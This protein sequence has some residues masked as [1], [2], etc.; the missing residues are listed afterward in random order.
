MKTTLT[1]MGLE[2]MNAMT[3]SCFNDQGDDFRTHG[4][5][6]FSVTDELVGTG[7]TKEVYMTVQQAKGVLS[8]LVKKNYV[9]ICDAEGWGRAPDMSVCMTKNGIRVWEKMLRSYADDYADYCL[10]TRPTEMEDK[11]AAEALA[12]LRQVEND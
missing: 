9:D 1:K 2:Y 11:Y 6:Q 5:W 8:S 10:E 4:V 7:F 3:R 12:I